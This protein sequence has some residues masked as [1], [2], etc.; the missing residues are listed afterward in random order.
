M[1]PTRE[2]GSNRQVATQL[3]RIVLIS[4][5]GSAL[6]LASPWTM[7]TRTT[8]GAGPGWRKGVMSLMPPPRGPE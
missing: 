8:S 2:I 6:A 3:P 7:V 1:P 4:T 5:R